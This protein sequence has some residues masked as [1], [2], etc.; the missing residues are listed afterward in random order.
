MGWG[1]RLARSPIRNP[2]HDRTVRIDQVSKLQ[3]AKMLN[4]QVERYRQLRHEHAIMM[5]ILLA[6]VSDPDALKAGGGTLTLDKLAYDHVVNG[7]T[8]NIAE[9]QDVLR[10]RKVAPPA[11]EVIPAV[12]MH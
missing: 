9:E 1:S 12:A 5:K 6:A 10:I 3:L 8:I 7:E 2:T 11:V 4:E